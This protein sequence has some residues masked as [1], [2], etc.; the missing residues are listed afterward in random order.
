MLQN[1][2]V[3][4]LALIRELDIAFDKGLNILT[5]ETGAGKSIILG[6]V[7]LALG[8]KYTKD[9]MREG[10]DYGLVELTFCPEEPECIR[11]LKE[12][13]IL[14]EDGCVLLSR[15]L[16]DGRSVSRI[17]GETVS[18]GTL[19][20][21]AS[22][23]L[24]IHGQHEH[25]T[26]L[27]RKNHLAILDAYGGKE[28]A[29]LKEQ[30]KTAYQ[31]YRELYEKLENASMDE[32]SRQKEMDFLAFEIDEIEKAD[33]RLGE[34]EELEEQYRRMS[35]SRKLTE[36]IAEAYH[37]TGGGDGADASDALSRAI[38]ALQ[39]V[40]D[41][42]ERGAELCGQLEEIDGLLNDFNR[43]L[44]EY[45]KSFEFSEEEFRET[46]DR[47]N[48]I[49]RLKS[50]YG[51]SVSEILAYGENQSERL[52]ELQ[53]YQ[54][55]MEQ[56][57][58]K[59]RQAEAELKSLSEKL[60]AVREKKKEELVKKIYTGLLELN[61]LDVR[62]DMELTKKEHYSA[63]GVDEAE[64]MIS[65]NPGEKLKPLGQVASGGELSR[66]MLAI[67]AVMA[68]REDTPTLIFDEIDT[69]ISGITAAKVAKQMHIIGKN[70]Q[71]ICITH[72]PQ[73]AAMA[74]H[75][76]LIEKSVADA[77]TVTEIKR[78]D[79]E[80]SVRE[81]A[82]LLGGDNITDRILESAREMKNLAKCEK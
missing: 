46:E 64:F 19:K 4:N 12:M 9:M 45:G 38:R 67:K 81:L 68:D 8:G 13:D 49:N 80:G 18:M 74:D 63:N 17:N 7:G 72:L 23:L 34:D 24:D 21:V 37:Y 52:A 29:G 78:L 59:I 53:N 2:H 82:R 31:G 75:H 40:A 47:L 14:L 26:L 10:A 48:E 79:Q 5:G 50:K 57:E 73:I 58:T 55:Y 28:I 20:D 1:L 30:V 39:D 66:I 71:V 25:Q 27:H 3:K 22:I 42:E 56:L 44:S 41:Y 65:T 11:K 36:S 76:Y 61:F 62:F 70:R 69:G 16:T 35:D 32:K 33:L 77:R 54:E 43:E 6:S 51:N 15:K 60:S